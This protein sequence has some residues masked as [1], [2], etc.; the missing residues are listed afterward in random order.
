[1]GRLCPVGYHQLPNIGLSLPCSAGVAGRD[2]VPLF[3]PLADES[4]ISN[5]LYP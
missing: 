4:A 3:P 5:E 2:A 1:M